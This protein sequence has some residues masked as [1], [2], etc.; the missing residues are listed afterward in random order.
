MSKY[1]GW[2]ILPHTPWGHFSFIL[3][4]IFVKIPVFPGCHSNFL[5][6]HFVFPKSH[7]AF[8]RVLVFKFSSYIINKADDVMKKKVKY[9]MKDA[10]DVYKI[11]WLTKVNE[12]WITTIFDFQTRINFMN[13]LKLFLTCYSSITLSANNTNFC[14]EDPRH[15][16]ATS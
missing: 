10:D 9:S 11:Q 2:Y 15:R 1:G 14:A 8:Q 7:L 5:K 6:S 12:L 16:T 13:I 4:S 3:L